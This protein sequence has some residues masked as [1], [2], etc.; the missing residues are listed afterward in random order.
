MVLICLWL[1]ANMAELKSCL[2][3]SIPSVDD[4]GQSRVSDCRTAVC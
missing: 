2:S 1:G 3:H 4:S